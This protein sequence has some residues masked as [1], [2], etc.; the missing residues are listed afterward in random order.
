MI[1][2]CASAYVYSIILLY[3]IV[4]IIMV[5][6]YTLTIIMPALKSAKWLLKVICFKT[7]VFKFKI[8]PM[9]IC[10]GPCFLNKSKWLEYLRWHLMCLVDWVYLLRILNSHYL[11]VCLHKYSSIK[12]RL[13]ICGRVLGF[14]WTAECGLESNTWNSSLSVKVGCRH[15]K[16]RM[17][18]ETYSM[19]NS[20]YVLNKLYFKLCIYRIL[21]IVNPYSI[22][23]Y[24]IR[25]AICYVFLFESF[26][27]QP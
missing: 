23:K 25:R 2:L 15:L 21:W 16:W 3:C 20:N 5:G 18:N 8:E 9:P 7:Y 13:Q 22:L 24:Y 12:S 14:L 19:Y 11:F 27:Q 26:P 10:N 4:S 17:Q 1:Q 6:I